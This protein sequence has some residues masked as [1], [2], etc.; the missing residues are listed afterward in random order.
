MGSPLGFWMKKFQVL[1]TEAQVMMVFIGSPMR[2]WVRMRT[3][4]ESHIFS[5]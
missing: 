5:M 2:I 4:K 1:Q 3:G